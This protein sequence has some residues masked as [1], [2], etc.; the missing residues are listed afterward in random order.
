MM[1]LLWDFHE[2]ACLE[3]R[4]RIAAL[5]GL[6]GEESRLPLD[7]AAHWTDL[8]KQ[9]ASSAMR[10]G[11]N[12]VKL[13]LLQHL[14]EFG[15]LVAPP[16]GS[17]PSRVPDWTKTRRKNLPYHSLRRS[18]DISGPSSNLPRYSALLAMGFTQETPQIYGALV[19]LGFT[20]ETLQIYGDAL[21]ST[22][23]DCN[24]TFAASI[25]QPSQDQDQCAERVIAV[26]RELFTAIPDA[27]AHLPTL[28][29]LVK[30]VARFR[31]R[32]VEERTLTLGTA[33]FDDFLE[34]IGQKLPERPSLET[35]NPLKDLPR[36]MT[37]G[38]LLV[39]GQ[40]HLGSGS[41][42]GYGLGPEGTQP[43][44]MMVPL[45]HP[46]W[47][48]NAPLFRPKDF[49]RKINAMTM[50]VV[51]PTGESCFQH[52]SGSLDEALR[53]GV[54]KATVVVAVTHVVIAQAN[55][56][57]ETVETQTV[58]PMATATASTFAGAPGRPAPCA[59]PFLDTSLRG[60]FVNPSNQEA[61]PVLLQPP[62][63]SLSARAKSPYM[64][65]IAL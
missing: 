62:N 61:G 15:P 58:A 53:Q 16:G 34:N 7:W 13:Q 17:Y 38:S 21:T 41:C 37:D 25:L 57:D 29:S 49:P 4:D 48:C 5:V 65:P 27:V 19:T 45:W 35:V 12:E 40:L 46:N 63:E 23:H 30:A 59:T 6:I 3:P 52:E 2:A 56:A 43:G 9:A 11:G 42:R 47:D 33:L 60:H 32:D 54:L 14:F 18:V 1:G 10:N 22:P 50:L 26:L 8:Y 39:L 64:I 44:D 24:V 36:V 31:Y 28:S 55:V 51:R 20:H